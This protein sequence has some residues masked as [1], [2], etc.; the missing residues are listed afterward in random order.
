MTHIPGCL[1]RHFSNN[2]ID[3]SKGNI[4]LGLAPSDQADHF[5]LGEYS[6]HGTDG[7]AS[8]GLSQLKQLIQ[9]DSE[10]IGHDFQKSAGAGRALVIH[11]EI[12][13]HSLVD[14]DNL[15]ILA[16]DINDREV[17]RAMY[18]AGSP[19]VTADFSDAPVGIGN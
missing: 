17:L 5:R 3:N 14:P 4:F 7:G 10:G 12:A 11:V 15:R 2:G 9:G 8:A 19:P 18:M 1:R 6:A 16:A 13:D